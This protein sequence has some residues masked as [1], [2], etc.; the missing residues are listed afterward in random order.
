MAQP[1]ASKAGRPIKSDCLLLD[2]GL[3]RRLADNHTPRAA[4]CCVG[5]HKA[6]G[7]FLDKQFSQVFLTEDLEMATIVDV[8]TCNGGPQVPLPG[9]HRAN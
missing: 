2:L 6:G 9:I 3:W 1:P 7:A 8:L 5:S 4:V